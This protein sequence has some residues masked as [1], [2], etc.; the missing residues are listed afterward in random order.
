MGQR[1]AGGIKRCAQQL[2]LRR[3]SS[4]AAKNSGTEVTRLPAAEL[5]HFRAFPAAVGVTRAP[6]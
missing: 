3:I 5:P 6:G 2:V 1:A 4:G